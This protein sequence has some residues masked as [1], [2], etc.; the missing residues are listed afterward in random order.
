MTTFV[1]DLFEGNG[2]VSSLS[3]SFNAGAANYLR[4]WVIAEGGVSVTSISFGAQT[5]TFITGSGVGD[6]IGC[7]EL[8]SPNSGAQT[9]TVNFNGTS[10]RCAF[11]A[12]SR[13]GVN[14]STPSGTPG[15]NSGT[16]TAASATASSAV[17]ELVE[18]IVHVAEATVT[19]DGGQ[20]ENENQADWISVFRSFSAAEKA[21][22]ASVTL[23]WTPPSSTDWFAVAIPVLPAAGGGGSTPKGLMLLGVG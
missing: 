3:N 23:N 9:I 10:G 6:V 16:S 2:G 18:G 14:T 4:I 20:T 15:T 21:G 12:V 13:S 8:L 17:G 11:Y 19:S 22:A 1:A 7:Y 5:P